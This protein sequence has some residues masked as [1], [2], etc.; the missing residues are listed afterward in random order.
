MQALEQAQIAVRAAAD[1]LTAARH[2]A[3]AAVTLASAQASQAQTQA[4]LALTD[5]QRQYQER[6]RE[7][8]DARLKLAE[9]ENVLATAITG[10]G[11]LAIRATVGGL[12]TGF[13]V[14]PGDQAPAGAAVAKVAM[15]ATMVV[16]LEVPESVSGPLRRGDGA[17]VHLVDSGREYP[18]VLR[19]IAPLPDEGGNYR[20]EVAF[21]NFSEERVSG[22]AAVVRVAVRR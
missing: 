15:V 5:Q 6:L 14:K 22:R 1:D 18:A 2:G 12:V 17:I 19:T 13:M 16:D 4:R 10:F 3:A 8:A 7:L 21:E 20:V 9:A 11:D